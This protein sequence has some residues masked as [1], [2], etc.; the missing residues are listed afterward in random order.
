[1]GGIEIR[2][3]VGGNQTQRESTGDLKTTEF[4]GTFK[5]NVYGWFWLCKAALKVMPAGASIVNTAS[6]QAYQPSDILVD[7]AST[8]ACIVAFT[9]ALAKQ[10]AEKGIRVNAVAPGPIWTALQPSGGQPMEKIR[11]FG[12]NVPLKR[13]GQPV[14]CAPLYVL[15]ASNE[16]SFV[17]GE[18]YGVTGGNPL[19]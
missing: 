9:K 19:P 14:E 2:V 7:Y 5:T 10:V 15:L 1:M 12:A 8:K 17:T 6:I 11:D 13:P 4:D 16:S 18:T 3:E